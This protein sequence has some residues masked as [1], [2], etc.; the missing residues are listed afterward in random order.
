M[1]DAKNYR[2]QTPDWLTSNDYQQPV[3]TAAPRSGIDWGGMLSGAVGGS[4]LGPIGTVAGAGLGFLGSL[5]NGGA[6][7]KQQGIVNKQNDRNQ[8]MSSLR[9]MKDDYLKALLR[10][11]GGI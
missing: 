4:A 11:R 3:A 8:N 5:I 10:S 1:P 7:Q 6:E 2:R 9:Y